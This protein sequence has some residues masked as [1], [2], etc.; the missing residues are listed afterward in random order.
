MTKGLY[1]GSFDPITIGHL[2]ILERAARLCDELTILVVRNY[3][4]K[5]LYSEAE[6]VEMIRRATAHIPNIH[7]DFLNGHLATFVLEN[8]YSVVYRGLRNN[9]DFDYEIQLAQIYAKYYNN[10]VETVYLMTDPRYS[11]ISSSI[12][13][14]NFMLGADVSGWVA[15]STLEYMKEL[16]KKQG[17]KK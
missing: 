15:P 4:K 5:L 17:E 6:R 8:D 7:I 14:E 12:V 11:Y 13:K 1:A 3:S 10:K 9:A 2:D 16:Q